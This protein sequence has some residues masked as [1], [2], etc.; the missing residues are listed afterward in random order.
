MERAGTGLARAVA[1]VA[2]GSPGPI[3]SSSAR[4]TTAATGSWRRACCARRAVRSTCSPRAARS[5]GGPA[6]NLERL[7]GARRAVRPA[8]PRGSGVVVD[9]LLGTGFSGE[10]R[11]P[12]AGAIAAINAQDAP[13]VACDVPSGVDA[14]DRARWRGEAVRAQVTATFHGSKVGLHVAPGALHAGEVE[15]V[16]IGVPRGRSGAVRGGADLRAGARA[17]PPPKPRGIEVHLGRGGHRGRRA[18]AHRR[19]HDGRARG[20]ARRGGLRA[21]GGARP[22]QTLPC[23]CSRR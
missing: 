23:A 19:A 6:V 16:E 2:A 22:Q 13:V 15:V 10:P 5:S 7:P 3:R 12:V 20:A 9:A 4:A 18:R 14:I 17:V 8:A 21:G 11:E 1:R